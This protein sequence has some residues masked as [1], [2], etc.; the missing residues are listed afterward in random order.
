M[1]RPT[2]RVT[3][4]R[5][6]KSRVALIP[7]SQSAPARHTAASYSRSY[8]WPGR[9]CSKPSRIAAS[10]ILEIQRRS[11][12]LLHPAYSYTSRKISS[13]SRPASVAH[14]TEST[15]LSFISRQRRSSC[16]FLSFGTSYFHSS[17]R[18]GKSP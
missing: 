10:S 13:P 3:P 16:F 5:T 9:K 4:Y 18:I 1:T 6:E 8:S 7:I 15:R 17:G 11:I 2:L 12:G 14:T